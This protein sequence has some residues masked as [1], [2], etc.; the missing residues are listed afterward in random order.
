MA[1][2]AGG[3]IINVGSI[4]SL[5]PRGGELVYGCAKAALNALTIGLADAYG[6][7]VRANAILPGPVATDIAKG[8]TE[9][10][11]AEIAKDIPLGR[12]GQAPDLVGAALWLASDASAWVSGT[13][14]RVDGGAYRQT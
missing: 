10:N 4:G 8:W 14:V 12:I 11:E 1:A 2:G 7:R 6:P 5:R 3:S 13:I 9:E